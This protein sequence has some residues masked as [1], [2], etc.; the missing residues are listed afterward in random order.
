V[1][2]FAGRDVVGDLNR[3]TALA[4]NETKRIFFFFRKV[5]RL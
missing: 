1:E 4:I 2:E 5:R 3:A